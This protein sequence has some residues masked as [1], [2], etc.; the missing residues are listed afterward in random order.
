M[1]DKTGAALDRRRALGIGAAVAGV[2]LAA[3]ACTSNSTPSGNEGNVNSINQLVTQQSNLTL[4]AYDKVAKNPACVYPAEQMTT[5]LELENLRKKLLMFNEP[6]KLGYVYLFTPMGQLI[7]YLPVQGKIS[8]TQSGMTAI[9]SVYAGGGTN[10]GG[11]VPVDMPADDLS[12]GPNE[13]GDAGIF[14]FTPDGVYVNWAGPYLYTDTPLNILAST[15][16]LE[17]K[18]GSKP[19]N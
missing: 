1:S 9:T 11:N 5:S 19:I 8:S 10:G 6:T 3:A 14:F 15:A 16:V 4:A 12:Y 18:N 7:A 13:G 2:G 17:Y